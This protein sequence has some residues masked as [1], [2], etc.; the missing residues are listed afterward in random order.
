MHIYRRQL[1]ESKRLAFF[2]L[3]RTGKVKV[4]DTNNWIK[5]SQMG[6]LS[7]AKCQNLILFIRDNKCLLHMPWNH[8]RQ[9]VFGGYEGHSVSIQVSNKD[10]NVYLFLNI[11]G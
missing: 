6:R 8:L 11:L 7:I 4:S 9:P 3:D 1:I 10:Q 2:P 5:I